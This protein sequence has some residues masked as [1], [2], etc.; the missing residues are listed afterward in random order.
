VTQTSMAEAAGLQYD[1]TTGGLYRIFWRNLLLTVVTFGIY[2]FWATTRMRR[3]LWAHMQF[4]GDRFEYTGTGGE[5][6]RG[7]LLALLV[8]AAIAAVNLGTAYLIRVSGNPAL[9]LLQLPVS[10]FYASLFGAAVFSAQR[11]R[12]SR[13]SWRG[14]RGGMESGAFAYGLKTV[15]YGMVTPFTLGLLWP[16]LRMRLIE[17]RIDAS[18]FGSGALATRGRGRALYP[19]FLLG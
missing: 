15:W 10:L 18:S 19:G 2:R 1:G 11:Y 16:I 12:L 5:K 6:F 7:F 3:Y 9:A 17:R 14:I 8:F 4:M 13:T